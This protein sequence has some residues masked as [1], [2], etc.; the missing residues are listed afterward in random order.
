MDSNSW[1][2][3]KEILTAALKLEASERQAFVREQ[4]RDNPALAN[5]VLELLANDRRTA[6]DPFE[7]PPQL[8][9]ADLGL[10][11]TTDSEQVDL[12]DDLTTG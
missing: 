4:C 9:G 11:H 6:D 1:E 2:R 12:F 7:R 5:G 3:V 8:Q 10:V